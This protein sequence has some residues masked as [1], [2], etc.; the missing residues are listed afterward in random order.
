MQPKTCLGSLLGFEVLM[1]GVLV[2]MQSAE[3]L[4]DEAGSSQPEE[5]AAHGG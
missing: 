2:A 4:P 3:N 1:E 5:N